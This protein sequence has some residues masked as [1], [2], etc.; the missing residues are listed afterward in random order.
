MRPEYEAQVRLVLQVLPHISLEPN[1][2]LRGAV[3][4]P[5]RRTV[6]DS[7]R[8]ALGYEGYVSMNVMSMPDPYGGKICAALDRQHPRDLFD[9]MVLFENEGITEDICKAFCVYLASHDRP[10]NELLA[11][12][13]LDVRQVFED[14]FTGMTERTVSYDE[15]VAARERLVESITSG[16]SAGERS[17]LL[18]V[19]RGEPA[20]D[21]LGVPGIERLPGL[22]WKLLNIRK[23]PKTKHDEA[24]AKL[25]NVLG[26]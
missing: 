8:R 11:P 1:L 24:C 22:Q 2:I 15:L 6:S 4:P 19:K 23:M 17:F 7:A 5:G 26:I 10:M 20:F 13:R 9:I 25:R 3:F 21:E 16:L 14:E 12:A 18:S